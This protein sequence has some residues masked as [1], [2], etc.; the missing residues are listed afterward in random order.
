LVSAAA[1]ASFIHIATHG[2]F[3]AGRS[4]AAKA[5]QL[6]LAE[7][8]PL[9]L[10]GLALTGANA[11]AS[12]S[13]SE[14]VITAEELATLDLSGCRLVVL[15]A[16]DTNVGTLSAGQGVASFQ[17]ALH[18]AGALQV[19]TALW[20]VDDRTTRE[21]MLEFYQGMW[22]DQLTPEQALWRAKSRRIA[23]RAPVRDWAGWVLSSQ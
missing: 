6:A 3:A 7:R 15:S 9:S 13:D 5:A 23:R 22:V 2:Y 19:V 20:T 1:H 11:E 8:S 18:A 16:C 14:G 4:S 21:L 12:S 17:K 10:C